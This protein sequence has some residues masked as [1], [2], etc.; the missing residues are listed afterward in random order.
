MKTQVGDIQATFVFNT[1]FVCVGNEMRIQ[2]SSLSQ[3]TRI[4]KYVVGEFFT[5][6]VKDAIKDE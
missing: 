1:I 3:N 4:Y 6:S 2:V 5:L